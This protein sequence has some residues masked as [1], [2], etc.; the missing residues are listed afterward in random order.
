MVATHIRKDLARYAL[1]DWCIEILGVYNMRDIANTFFRQ[2]CHR[3]Y[4]IGAFALLVHLFIYLML[5]FLAK[6]K[7][8]HV[9]FF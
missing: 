3:M 8:L 5:L 9:P 6:Q 7:S 2:F 1:C 4:V